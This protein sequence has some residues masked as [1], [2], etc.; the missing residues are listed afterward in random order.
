MPDDNWTIGRHRG[1]LALVFYRDGKRHR[2]ALGTSD[3]SKARSLAPSIYAELT[4]PKG[5]TVKDLWKAYE[6]DKEGRAIVATMKH[7]WKALEEVFGGLEPRD[8]TIEHCRAHTRDRRKAGIK[9]GTIHTELGHLRMVL[10]WARERK[11]YDEEVPTIER[12]PKPKTG[13]RHLTRQEV[14]AVLRHCRTPHIK[15]FIHLG[16]ATAGRSAAILGL[17]WDRVDFERGKIDLE[18]PEIAAPHKG[19]A[20]VP[21]TRTLRAVLQEAKQGA[22]SP[23]VIEWAGDRAGS[24]KKGLASAAKRAGVPKLTPHMLRHSAA[25]RMA[26]DGV[27]MEEIASYLGHSDVSITRKVYARFSPDA[28]REAANALELDDM[29]EVSADD[30]GT[31]V[32][33]RKGLR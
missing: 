22:L 28:L 11:F 18:D 20:V 30:A 4:R 25:V 8:V 3:P 26:E 2:H 10:K 31:D 9:D 24:L 12:P 23:F 32:P 13:E 15:R 19:R 1:G 33:K 16:Y 14:K 7:T 29:D 17:T 21:M 27:K 6:I 5:K